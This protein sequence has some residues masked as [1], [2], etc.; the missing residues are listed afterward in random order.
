MKLITVK[1]LKKISA[2]GKIGDYLRRHPA[3]LSNLIGKPA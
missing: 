1:K 3:I 2:N